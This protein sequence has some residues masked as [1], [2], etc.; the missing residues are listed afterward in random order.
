MAIPS[1]RNIL[2]KEVENFSKYRDLE[3]ETGKLWKMRATTTPVVVGALGV[4]KKGKTSNNE[5]IP[6][7]IYLEELQ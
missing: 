4:I 5:K 1:D 6:G 3:I 7:K 2:I